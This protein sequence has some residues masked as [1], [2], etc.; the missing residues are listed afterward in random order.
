MNNIQFGK[1]NYGINFLSNSNNS[2]IKEFSSRNPSTAKLLRPN[3]L[4]DLK[5]S[6]IKPLDATPIGKIIEQKTPPNNPNSSIRD[7][8]SLRHLI[9]SNKPVLSSD[10]EKLQ[11]NL[12][13]TAEIVKPPDLTDYRNLITRQQNAMKK[14]DGSLFNFGGKIYGEGYKGLV[15]D[16]LYKKRDNKTLFYDISK[17]SNNK[18]KLFGKNKIILKEKNNIINLIKNRNDLIVKKFKSYLW[19]LNDDIHNFKNELTGF[20][21]LINN[22]GINNIKKYTTIKPLTIINN[23]EIY[24]IKIDNSYYTFAEKCNNT[25]DNIKL[26]QKLFNQFIKDIMKILIILKKNHYYHNDLKPDN[27]IYCDNTFKLIDWELSRKIKNKPDSILYNGTLLF[28][29]PIKLYI[30]GIPSFIC[31]LTMDLPLLFNKKFKWIGK[32]KCFNEYKKRTLDSFDR[33]LKLNL[34]SEKMHKLFTKYFDNYAFALNIAFLAEKNKLKEPKDIID[35]L[36][37]PLEYPKI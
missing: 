26:N 17:S 12:Q 3:N 20:Y 35:K 22:F 2:N 4:R 29:H 30:K 19:F 15:K 8:I 10:I 6:K 34:S 9:N 27:I 33:I 23:H 5:I 11:I 32:L 31:K 24:G 25:L 7:N 36:M 37:K 16:V 14:R 21:E 18:I 28:N 1:P 13:N